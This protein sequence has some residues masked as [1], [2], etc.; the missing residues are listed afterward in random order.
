MKHVTKFLRSAFTFLL[1]LLGIAG[2][3]FK[4]LLQIVT[5]TLIC[6]GVIGLIVYIKLKPE[7]DKCLVTVYDKT[8]QMERSDFSLLSDTE[9]FDKDGNRIGLINSGHYEYVG[10]SDI[11]Q[12]IQ[13]A[14]IAQEDRRFKTHNGVDYIATF[15][16]GLALLKHSGNITQGGSTITQQVVKNTYLTREQ[17]FTRKMIEILL[18]PEIEKKFSKADIMEFY[19]N[20]NFYGNQCYGVEAASKFYFGKRAIDLEPHEAAVLVGLSNSPS[21]YDPVRHPEA[22][23]EKRNEVLASMKDVGFLSETE[24][25]NYTQKELVILQV[26]GEATDENYQSSYAIHCAALELMKLDGFDFQYTFENKEDYDA[27]FERYD[28]AYSEKASL[29]R[30]GGYKIYTSL[31]NNIQ[32]ILQNSI[33]ETL[34]PYTE[35]QDNGKYALQ[36]AGVIVDNQSNYVVAIVGGRGTEDV[37]NRAYISARQPGSTIKPLIDYAPAFDTGTYYPTRIVNDHLWEDGPQNS[38]R[39]YYGNVTVREALNRSLNTVA[40]QVLQDIGINFGLEYLG[41]MHF[42]KITY[43]DNGVQSL[44]IGGFTNGLRVVDMAK[45]YSTLANN[46]VYD[47]RTCITSIMHEHEGEILK[48]INYNTQQIYQED[49]A[50]MITDIMKGTFESTGT[51]RGLGLNGMP[52]AGKTGTTNSSKDTWFCGYSRYYTGAIWVGYDIPRPMPGIFGST[53]AGRIWKNTMAQIH[54][55]L[56]PLDWQGPNTIITANYNRST[57]ERIKTGTDEELAQTNVFVPRS[58]GRNDYFSLTADL[59]AQAAI[60]E[61]EQR[62]I[63]DAIKAELDVFESE[64]VNNADDAIRVT[65]QYNSITAKMA[66]LDAGEERQKIYDRLE[67]KYAELKP[68]LSSRQDEIQQYLESVAADEEVKRQQEAAQAARRAAEREAQKKREAARAVQENT[69][70]PQPQPQPQQPQDN[71]QPTPDPT[72]PPTEAPKIIEGVDGGPGVSQ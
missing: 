36:G 30:A 41:R 47:E 29:I 56:E 5:V 70:R 50:F 66:N 12:N 68:S 22:C 63:A 57:G 58:P 2:V 1:S 24:Y 10:I 51:A 21:A 25:R 39:H 48:D 45:G 8:S 60:Y 13:N 67:A 17:N 20:T 34:S 59:R 49:T 4:T 52:V 26:E 14:Y 43:I 15:R 18:A 69:Q 28:D 9:I 33:D 32:Q 53:Y 11:S 19:C 31:D 72:P 44:S 71:P 61:K 7:V 55:G 42:Q 46:G 27:Y 65:S 37:F 35:I 38:G 40:W 64:S 23:I 62:Q 6:A 54:E 3:I 16:A